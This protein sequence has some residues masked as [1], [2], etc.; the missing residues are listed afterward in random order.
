MNNCNSIYNRNNIF[1][2]ESQIN[3]DNNKKTFLEGIGDLVEKKMLIKEALFIAKEH[4]KGKDV[5]ICNNNKSLSTI[6]EKAETVNEKTKETFSPQNEKKIEKEK[7]NTNNDSDFDFS[8]DNSSNVF[9]LDFDK[10][11]NNNNSDNL[12]EDNDCNSFFG[13]IND[14]KNDN[15]P[16]SRLNS[17]SLIPRCI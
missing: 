16:F 5:C 12:L 11:L 15:F 14:K 13:R 17:L 1:K 8:E 3:E 2:N 7:D 9:N 10:F 4:E 6:E